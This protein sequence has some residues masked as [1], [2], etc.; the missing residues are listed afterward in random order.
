MSR[1]LPQQ[2]AVLNYCPKVPMPISFSVHFQLLHLA[3]PS[4]GTPMFYF[5]CRV[6][7]FLLEVRK[8]RA[9]FSFRVRSADGGGERGRRAADSVRVRP[10]VR[11][12]GG[13][14]RLP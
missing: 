7:L 2:E 11:R 12:P 6:K 10:S 5:C 3:Y 4:V 9:G 8:C 14:S 1:I 13:G